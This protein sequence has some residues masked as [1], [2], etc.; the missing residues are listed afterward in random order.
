MK[1]MSYLS[2]EQMKKGLQTEGTV[3][4]IN[5]QNSLEF[6]RN[7]KHFDITNEKQWDKAGQAYGGWKISFS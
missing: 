6:S 3:Y 5:V 4:S 2:R 1:T 7:H